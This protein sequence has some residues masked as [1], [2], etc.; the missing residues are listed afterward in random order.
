MNQITRTRAVGASIKFCEILMGRA[1]IYP[2]FARLHSWDIAAGH[3]LAREAG[4]HVV[5]LMTGADPS[6]DS[7]F[8][9]M[10]PF[11]VSTIV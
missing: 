6:Y 11:M 9:K 8:E 4:H 2:R 5:D 1:T 3:I 7:P 10:N